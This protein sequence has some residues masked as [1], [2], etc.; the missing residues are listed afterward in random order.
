MI[1]TDWETFFELAGTNSSITRKIGGLYRSWHCIIH[2]CPW[3]KF[4]ENLN[5]FTVLIDHRHNTCIEVFIFRLLCVSLFHLIRVST[6]WCA[7]FNFSDFA[8]V[9]TSLCFIFVCGWVKW[10]KCISPQMHHEG[11]RGA[12]RSPSIRLGFQM[13]PGNGLSTCIMLFLLLTAW[14]RIQST[15]HCAVA[16]IQKI[17]DRCKKPITC[18]LGRTHILFNAGKSCSFSFLFFNL[19]YLW[20]R[21]SVTWSPS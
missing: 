7:L 6:T 18:N 2:S 13:F 1:L 11:P 10:P 5:F 14:G 19:F 3:N 12:A 16:Y 4:T 20:L 9:V 8:T 15:Q 17:S 21:W